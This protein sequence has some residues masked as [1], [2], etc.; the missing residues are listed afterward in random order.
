MAS[1]FG[2]INVLLVTSGAVLLYSG[3]KRR[4]PL[5]V[6][7]S[8]FGLEPAATLPVKGAGG[9]GPDA[10]Q[11]ADNVA[12]KILDTHKEQVYDKLPEPV[13]K[14]DQG[15]ANL[16]KAALLVPMLQLKRSW[17]NTADFI[18]GIGK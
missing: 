17:D 2:T 14:V 12:D 15:L 3:I 5:N 1:D 4:S 7:K 10:A 6:V 18:S 13:K 8:A 9:G 11:T 16:N